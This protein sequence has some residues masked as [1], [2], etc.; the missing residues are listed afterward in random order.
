MEQSQQAQQARRQFFSERNEQMLYGILSK[1]YQQRLGTLNDKQMEHLG[2]ALEFF[3]SDVYEKSPYQPLPTLNKQVLTLTANEFNAYIQRQ[4]SL[5]NATPQMFME[6]SNRYEQ[7]QNERQRTLEAPRPSIP[8]YVQPIIIKED[9][10][11]SAMTL[12][13]EAKKRRDAEMNQQANAELIKRSASSSSPIY[14]EQQSQI[15]Q[16]PDP[17]VLFDSPLDL[18][19]AGFSTNVRLS[20]WVICSS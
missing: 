2:G 3:M 1:N 7:L 20:R 9:D 4:S 12:Y 14:T 6:T 18:V 8:D 15:V 17:K 5:V 11:I 19:V 16:R 13:E 10:S